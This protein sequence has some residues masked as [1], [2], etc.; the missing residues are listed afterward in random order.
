MKKTITASLAAGFILLFFSLGTMYLLITVFP[1]IAEEY[2]SPVF[3]WSSAGTDWMFYTH[4]FVLSFALKWF[5]ERY[6]EIFKGGVI[7]RA[8]EVALVYGIVALL[9]VLWLTFSAIDISVLM[10]GSWLGYG[11]VQAFIAG[12]IFAKINP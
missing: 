4:P 2:F 6:K 8:I 5:W 7:L 10:V 12:L 1:K 3:R 9:P 11:V